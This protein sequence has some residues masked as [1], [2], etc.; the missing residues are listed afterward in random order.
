[1]VLALLLLATGA[2]SGF[3]EDPYKVLG[4]RRSA[5]EA[6]IKRAYRELALKWHPDKVARQARVD[7]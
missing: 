1:M 5:T 7:F 4:V 6:E 3:H 2:A